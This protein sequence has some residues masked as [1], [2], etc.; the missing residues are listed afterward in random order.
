MLSIYGVSPF[1][2][3]PVEAKN[4]S[5]NRDGLGTEILLQ[6]SDK[7]CFSEPLCYF[8]RLMLLACHAFC[9]I[10]EMRK[11]VYFLRSSSGDLESKS[12]RPAG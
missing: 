10:A 3:V 11:E 2:I 1:Q 8:V 12:E 5:R 6:L 7:L 4:N 9:Y